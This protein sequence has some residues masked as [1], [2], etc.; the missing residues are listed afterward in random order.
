MREARLEATLL[1][2]KF[3]FPPPPPTQEIPVPRFARAS[4][5]GHFG[6]CNGKMGSPTSQPQKQQPGGT[7]RQGSQLPALPRPQPAQPVADKPE[8]PQEA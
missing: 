3:R 1:K 7:S 2:S 4:L 5:E 6:N 8:G